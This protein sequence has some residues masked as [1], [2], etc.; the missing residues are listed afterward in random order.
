MSRFSISFFILTA[1]VFMFSFTSS[2]KGI[3]KSKFPNMIGEYELIVIYSDGV[4]VEQAIPGKITMKI[5]KGDDL[6]IYNNGKK[7]SKYEFNDRRSPLPMGTEDYIMFNEKN[8]NSALFY[9]GDTIIQIL[10]PNTYSEN[11]FRKVK[12]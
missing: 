9:K 8:E 10:Y 4:P 11:Y 5:T 2:Q 6:Y 3:I 12:P 7:V 1:S